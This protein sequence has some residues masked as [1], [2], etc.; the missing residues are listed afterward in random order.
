MS[1]DD[2]VTGWIN[3]PRR[4]PKLGGLAAFAKA[5]AAEEAA[6][7][8]IFQFASIRACF[9]GGLRNITWS[10][11]NDRL[12]APAP[13]AFGALS[14]VGGVIVQVH[15]CLF[16]ATKCE[17]IITAD[18]SDVKGLVRAWTDHLSRT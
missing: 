3:A 13:K 9:P 11:V 15:R 5:T 14:G 1:N 6:A 8:C 16:A 17:I 4:M 2:S 10:R 12:T 7:P 18:V